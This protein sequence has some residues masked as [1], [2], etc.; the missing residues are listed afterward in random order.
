MSKLNKINYLLFSGLRKSSHKK[1]TTV[2][3]CNS[4]TYKCAFKQAQFQKR[5]EKDLVEETKSVPN[6]G[7]VER[8]TYFKVR[9]HTNKKIIQIV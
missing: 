2:L 5:I 3:G 7:K 6:Q 9:I 8:P 4:Y 1:N